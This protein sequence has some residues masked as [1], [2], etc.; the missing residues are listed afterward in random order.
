MKTKLL[1]IPLLAVGLLTGCN[2]QG[3]PN[4]LADYGTIQFDEADY[5]CGEGSY[6]EFFLDINVGRCLANDSS[7][8]FHFS[9]SYTLDKSYTISVSKG[10]LAK[11]TVDETNNEYF[12]ISTAH[13]VGDFILKIENALGALVYRNVVHVRKAYAKEE[14]AKALF[15]IDKYETPKGYGTYLGQWRL[16][17]ISSNPMTGSFAGGDDQDANV[18]ISFTTQY[19]SYS[20]YSDCYVYTVNTI[21][22]NTQLTTL[23]EIAI[24]RCLDSVYIYA[25]ASGESSLL[26]IVTTSI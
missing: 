17:F 12:T 5:I 3:D 2:N 26:T 25:T 10:A 20:E 16:S 9:S 8:K 4:A 15:K 14:M 18:S 22:S 7:Y 24:A 23:T 19:T 11:Y 6:G 21:S 13:G 1:F